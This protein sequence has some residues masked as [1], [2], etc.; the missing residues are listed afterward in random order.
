MEWQ[1][2]LGHENSLTTILSNRLESINSL[3]S[4]IVMGL[5]AHGRRGLLIDSYALEGEINSMLKLL[6]K[7]VPAETPVVSGS[8]MRS[9]ISKV[10]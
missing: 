4:L 3:S 2:F 6:T 7:K 10:N 5:M 9:S 1:R 8:G